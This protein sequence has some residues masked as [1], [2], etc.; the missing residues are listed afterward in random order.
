MKSLAGSGRSALL[1]LA[2]PFYATPLLAQAVTPP[3]AAPTRE[4]IERVPTTPAPQQRSRLRVDG[5]VERAPCPLA[6]PRFAD[7]KVTLNEV[8]FDNLRVVSPELL[9]SSYQAYL[10]REVPIA[11]VCEIRDAAATA[12]RR[13][14]YLAA[15]QVP[16]QRIE[17]GVVRF[18]VLM[19]KLVAVQ[20]R[21]DAGSS[22]KLIAGYLEKLTGAEAFNEKQAERYLL[23]ARDLP[24]YDI[25]LTLRPAG[26]QPGEVI[27]EVTVE[28]HAFGLDANIQNYGSRDVGRFGGFVR[29]EAYDL[30]GSGDRLSLGLFNTFDTEEQT[31]AQAGYDIR[32]GAEGL[33]LGG[34]FTY[35]WTKP[36]ITDPV[37]GQV[38]SRTL[39]A[40]LEA[41]YPFL[42]SQSSNVRGAFGLDYIN[43]RVR[44]DALPV[45]RDRL[46]VLYARADIETIDRA[47]IVS[48]AGYTVMEPKWRVAGSIELRKGLSIFDATDRCGPPP[49]S[50]CL[51]VGNVPPSRIEGSP[52]AA[53]VRVGGIAEYR[54]LPTIAFT[55]S[56]RVQYTRSPLLS[57]EEYSAGN[58]TIGRGYDPGTIVGDRGAGFQAEIRVGRLTPKARNDISLQP[59]A[60]FDAAWVWNIRS[61]QIPPPPSPDKLYSAGVGL[62]AAYGDRARL[63]VTLANPLRRAGLQTER[64]DARLLV[65]LT[66][67]LLPW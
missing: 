37:N 9:R 31:V 58:Y 16:P 42:R 67:K 4:E 62:R 6:D 32:V 7:V 33:T 41:T 18:D 52:T 27:G 54:P 13:E 15:V 1:L 21:G 65:S 11:T 49:F 47:S 66:T 38:R 48:T 57:Y 40:T 45:T 28:R 55:L 46:R 51:G 26:T 43:Q 44:V 23:L 39:L 30:L 14:G 60:F 36:S 25:R 22:E 3:P 35:A 53:V 64:G 56:P 12:L 61:P 19:A 10:G 5:G 34:R 2:F 8:V 50:R 29:A 20:V 59:Y 17:N 63:D 24:G